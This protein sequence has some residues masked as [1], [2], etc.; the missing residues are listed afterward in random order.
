M[1]NIATILL[2]TKMR[3]HWL[4]IT[5]NV[6]IWIV[7]LMTSL[8]C[9][10]LAV[11]WYC[12]RLLIVMFDQRRLLVH[13]L[14]RIY[15]WRRHFGLMAWTTWNMHGRYSRAFV[16]QIER[17]LYLFSWEWQLIR[18]LASVTCFNIGIP[19][20]A[21]SYNNTLFKKQLRVPW[22]QND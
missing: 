20:V 8:I 9:S 12:E 10:L 3:L 13:V 22:I 16:H 2:C 11:V 21:S 7:I 17:D 6:A 1:S 5:L 18:A 4:K 19:L 14:R 15:K